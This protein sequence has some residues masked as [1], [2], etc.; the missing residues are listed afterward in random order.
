MRV[1]LLAV[2]C[3]GLL[4]VHSRACDLSASGLL[5]LQRLQRAK[6][7]TCAEEK[8]KSRW[9][10]PACSLTGVDLSQGGRVLERGG[11]ERVEEGPRN[12]QGAS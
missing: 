5:D 11:A 7:P 12:M 6:M 9:C 8:H 10:E 4:N 1:S 2:T 3:V